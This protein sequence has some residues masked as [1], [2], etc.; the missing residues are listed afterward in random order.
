MTDCSI[1]LGKL[2]S[3]QT[4]KLS[5]GHEFHFDCY[6]KCVFINDINIFIKCPLC[7]EVNTNNK[8]LFDDPLQNIKLLNPIQRCCHKTKSGKRCKNKSHIFNYGYCYTHNKDVLPKDKYELFCEY[9][10]WLLDASNKTRTKLAMIDIG[11]KL[12]MKHPEI[13]TISEILYYFYRFYHCND[14][15]TLVE[16][17]IMYNYY[18][19]DIP[20]DD[21]LSKCLKDTIII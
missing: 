12:I 8:R 18:E 7:R 13:E 10:Y 21:W 4:Y 2:G 3:K 6:M 9:I 11:K 15:V 14:K 16:K 17:H 1:C 20:P 5:C 19:L